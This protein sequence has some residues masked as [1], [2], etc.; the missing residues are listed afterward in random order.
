LKISFPEFMQK[1]NGSRVAG[2]WINPRGARPEG[3]SV[4]LRVDSSMDQIKI[5]LR[6]CDMISQA[7]NS[8]CA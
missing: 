6:Q 5:V 2:V 4:D 8:G 1:F 7:G 3:L